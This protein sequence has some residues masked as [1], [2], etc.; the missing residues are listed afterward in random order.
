MDFLR[1]LRNPRYQRLRLADT[2][3]VRHVAIIQPEYLRLILAV[4]EQVEA[5]LPQNR[6]G[7]FGR[8][9][10]GDLIY[11]KAR[12]GGFGPCFVVPGVDEFENLSPPLAAMLFRRYNAL[13]C[14]DAAYW[15]GKQ[16]ARFGSFI[17]LAD[18]RAIHHGPDYRDAPGFS[19]R[20]A[21]I[22][23]RRA[24]VRPAS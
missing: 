23:L 5:R 14:G 2:C 9:S 10:P 12:S 1:A 21:W 16:H 7:P 8:A 19:P 18:A 15:T 3:G 24:P 17:H 20:S 6:V 13:A 4:R 22:V 11:F